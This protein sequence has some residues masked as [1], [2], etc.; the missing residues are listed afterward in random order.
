MSGTIRATTQT[1]L[2]DLTHLT[3]DERGIIQTRLAQTTQL[4]QKKADIVLEQIVVS[5]L[6]SVASLGFGG[7]FGTGFYMV[8]RASEA[9]NNLGNYINANA[10]S[11]NFIDRGYCHDLELRILHKQLPLAETLTQIDAVNTEI[12]NDIEALY[13]GTASVFAILGFAGGSML[14]RLP[15]VHNLFSFLPSV[16]PAAKPLFVSGIV[17][18]TLSTASLAAG[19]ELSKLSNTPHP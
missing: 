18:N 13:S 15:A 11:G 16:L 6:A 9:F 7:I 1:L 10:W 19:A 4:L 5:T 17:H 2:A 3:N 12:N 14:H 8:L